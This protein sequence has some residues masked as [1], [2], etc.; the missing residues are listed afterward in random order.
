MTD[1]LSQPV[2]DASPLEQPFSMQEVLPIANIGGIL[3]TFSSHI[4]QFPC[5]EFETIR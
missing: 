2:V 3:A 5:H 1:M 4:I